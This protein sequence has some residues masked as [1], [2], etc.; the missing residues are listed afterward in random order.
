MKGRKT[1]TI[2]THNV[3]VSFDWK[4]YTKL[5]SYAEQHNSTVEK[6][7]ELLVKQ[8]LEKINK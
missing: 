4:V 6:T 1:M 3:T 7:I 5:V 8:Q 2:S